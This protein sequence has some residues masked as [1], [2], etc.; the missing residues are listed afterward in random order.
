MLRDCKNDSLLK[1]SF[2]YSLKLGNI[3]PVHKKDETADEENYR[4]VSILSL[5]QDILKD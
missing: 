4:P 2:P 1:F 5:F 3:T